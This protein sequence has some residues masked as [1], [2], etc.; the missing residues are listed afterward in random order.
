LT[1][2]DISVQENYDYVANKRTFSGY[3]VTR[4]FSVKLTDFS[5][6]P[7]IVNG[8][9]ELRI[10]SLN[11]AQ[12]S[13]SKADAESA[14]LKTAAL[15][16][17]RQQADDIAASL[18]AKVVSVFAVSPIEFGEIPRAIFGGTGGAMPMT[19]TYMSRDLSGS[20]GDKYV[21]NQLNFSER[22]HVI[23]LIEPKK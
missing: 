4:N 10:D 22:L 2:F 20:T 16:Q 11:G 5:L 14:K 23:F 13:S 8:L 19:K 1:A 6:Y 18:G 12:P 3:T 15:A 21:F 7:K 17:A 9:V